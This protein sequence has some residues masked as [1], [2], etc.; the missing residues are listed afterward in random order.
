[1][2]GLLLRSFLPTVFLLFVCVLALAGLA[3]ARHKKAAQPCVPRKLDGDSVVCV[4]NATYC[5]S[6]PPVSPTRATNNGSYSLYRSTLDGQRFNKTQGSFSKSHHPSA[7]SLTL[8][9][10]NTTRQNILGFGGA[11]TDAAGVNIL[12]LSPPAQDN[13]LSSYY[14]P[15][16]IEYSI[17]RVNMAGCDF[18]T[19]VYT[20]DD[21]PGDLKLDH[22]ALTPEDNKMKI[23]LIQRAQALTKTAIRVFASPWSAPGWMKT[24]GNASTSGTL[25]GQAGSDYSKAWA[26]YF[27]KF[28]QAYEAQNITIWGITAQNEPSDGMIPHFPFN[29]LGFTAATQ[30]DFI[31]SDLGPALTAAGLRRVK[32][33]IMDDQRVLL[34][35]WADT[36]LS[37]SRMNWESKSDAADFVDGIAVHWYADPITPASVLSKTHDH[38]PDKFILST[39]ACE[40]SYPW[41]K[42]VI[43]GD[44][45]RAE[46]YAV[47]IIENLQ[48]WVSG[49]TDWNLALN[50]QGGPNWAN[51]F[52]D[53]PI[54]VNNTADELYKQPMFY[55]LGHFSKFLSP[56]AQI[57]TTDLSGW[58]LGQKVMAV[59]AQRPDGGVAAVVLNR[60]DADVQ[61]EIR[62]QRLGRG[63]IVENIPKRSL[64]TFVWW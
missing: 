46:S 30:R 23:P 62:D 54:I 51:N 34:P 17:G 10:A 38:H 55:A 35:G 19:H 5:D 47:D 39:E 63:R 57:L 58:N 27:V 32:L 1:M 16:G 64:Q 2:A 25:K 18:S 56:D 52:V 13:L 31:A 53:A 14:G 29:A 45:G 41:Q 3:T 33:M 49:W 28:I 8:T 15:N 61:L 12:Q 42:K 4:C 48:N 43:L 26:Q 11:F 20:Y 37:K 6:L 9:I 7:A 44:W 21:T 24:S 36:V 50:P 60:G 22:F 40:G 59:A